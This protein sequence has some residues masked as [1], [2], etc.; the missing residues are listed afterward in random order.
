MKF[1]CDISR[2]HQA[3]CE[4]LGVFQ[5]LFVRVPLVLHHE[6]PEADRTQAAELNDDPESFI[7]EL[8]LDQFAVD[9]L[10]PPGRRAGGPA[11]AD[12]SCR[13]RAADQLRDL[14]AIGMVRDRIRAGKG[15][16]ED[17]GVIAIQF[18]L[19]F[20]SPGPPHPVPAPPH[21]E[22]GPWERVYIH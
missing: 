8:F 15:K 19:I 2:Q 10:R 7:H 14:G 18:V 4:C 1:K 16:R 11:R 21:R 9:H 13:G 12:R 5:I 6:K 20:L 17:E 3:S 22:A